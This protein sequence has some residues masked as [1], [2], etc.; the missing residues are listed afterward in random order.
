MSSL[1]ERLKTLTKPFHDETESHGFGKKIF[2]KTIT[3]D[4]YCTMLD[5]FH[6]V[7]SPLEE[8]I[9]SKKSEFEILALDITK[10]LKSSIIRDDMAGLGRA[11]SKA[12]VTAV[13]GSDF[14]SLVGA[15]YVLEGSTMGGQMIAKELKELG[16]PFG[17][18]LPYGEVTMPMWQE[19]I[20]FLERCEKKEGFD[21]EA[22]ILG[23]CAMFLYMRR[24]F[25]K[26]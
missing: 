21:V 14:S 5:I 10:R 24:E 16:L 22:C 7:V 25:K 20:G 26:Y 4:E 13:R 9:L 19:F 15:V 6:S 11:P 2:E 12:M 23:A 18:F 3:K 8:V 1:R 17:Y